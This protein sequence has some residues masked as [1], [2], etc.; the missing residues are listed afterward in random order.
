MPA[1]NAQPAMN[2]LQRFLLFC[3]IASSLLYVAINIIT[4][5]YFPG[6]DIA[7]QTVSELS[8]IDAPS[9]PLWVGLCSFYSVFVI[10]FGCGIWIAGHDN[11]RLRTA[12]ILLLLYGISGFFWPPMHLRE[13]IA[14]GGGTLTD[15]MHIAFAIGTILLMILI[16]GF[17]A[18]A[19]GR[20]FRDF[21][22]LTIVIFIVFGSLTGKESPGISS[23][24]PTPWIGVW[25][26]IN[27]GMFMIWMM[28]FAV[29]LLRLTK[30]KVPNQV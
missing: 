26:R 1:G 7:S 15:T 2:L 8:A 13:V 21:S 19:L 23:G 22:I 5:F 14:A 12:A 10:A 6:Y 18:T 4:P 16:I 3:G 11:R 24:Q 25:E 30:D 27:I 20:S 29:V 17:A 9:R 28:V